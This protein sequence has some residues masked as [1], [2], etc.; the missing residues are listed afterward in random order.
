MNSTKGKTQQTQYTVLC[1]RQ[2]RNIFFK[3]STKLLLIA[4]KREFN[5]EWSI[6]TEQNVTL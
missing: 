3:T 4:F 2:A 5:K 6:L 1:I